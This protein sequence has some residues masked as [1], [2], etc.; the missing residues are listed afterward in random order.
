MRGNDVILKS[1]PHMDFG[2]NFPQKSEESIAKSE[3]ITSLKAQIEDLY[4]QL[5][6]AKNPS[7]KVANDKKDE[8]V[9]DEPHLEDA[10]KTLED[11]PVAEEDLLGMLSC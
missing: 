4:K 6:E 10:I 8:D 1:V 2:H 5:A 11:D 3:L 9:M 7:P